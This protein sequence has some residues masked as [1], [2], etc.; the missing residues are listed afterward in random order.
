MLAAV[1]GLVGVVIGVVLSALQSLWSERREVQRETIR[2]ERDIEAALINADGRLA[3]TLQREQWW[4]INHPLPTAAFEGASAHLDPDIPQKTLE[5][6]REVFRALSLLEALVA[7]RRR[8]APASS[9]PGSESTTAESASTPRTT[10]LPLKGGEFQVVK[11]SHAQVLEALGL[12]RDRRRRRALR[13][14]HVALSLATVLASVLLAGIASGLYF[15]IRQ[16]EAPTPI[17]AKT[18]AASLK[19]TLHADFASCDLEAESR[20]N[21][22]CVLADFATSNRCDAVVAAKQ[23]RTRM[24][25]SVVADPVN[26]TECVTKE[27]A[28]AVEVAPDS[29]WILS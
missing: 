3:T 6:I 27:D 19:S 13:R 16:I 28:V 24:A 22:A 18:L 14:R 5:K 12:L 23:L 17:N 7:A 4:P 1:I 29:D 8:E 2:A 26:K 15:G 25:S 20:S 21:Y 11:D 10:T 9:P